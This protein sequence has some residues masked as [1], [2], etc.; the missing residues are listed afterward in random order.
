M[1]PHLL[2]LLLLILPMVGIPSIFGTDKA[3]RYEEDHTTWVYPPWEHTWGIVRATQTHLT[4]YSMGASQFINP[5]GLAVVR[6]DASNDPE[7]R[8]DD[9][10]VTVYGVNSGE[11][12]II[13]NKSMTS[14]GFYNGENIPDKPLDQPWDIAALV[15]GLVYITDAGNQRIIKLRNVN[16]ELEYVATFGMADSVG[17]VLPRGVDATD[18]GRVVV[19]DA[20]SNRVLLFDSTGVLTG[21]LTGF[22]RPVGLAAVDSETIFLRPPRDYIVVSDSGGRRIRKLTY[23][24]TLLHE[25]DVAEATGLEN[26]YVGHLAIDLFHNIIATD[27]VNNCILKFDNELDILAVWGQKGKGRS[28]FVGPTGIAAW[29]RFGQTFVAEQGGAHYLWVGTD[30]THPP[31]LSIEKGPIIRLK[32][33]LTERSRITLRLLDRKGELVQDLRATRSAGEQSLNW[34]LNRKQ[35]PLHLDSDDP[36]RVSRLQPPEPGRYILEI[37]LR[38]SYSSSKAFEKVVETEVELTPDLYTN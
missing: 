26:P 15:N 36:I 13:Y 27:S 23:A 35:T 31:R 20:G 28:R 5:Q 38:A 9:D 25:V 22:D 7:S 1:I 4:F 21:E 24:G 8:G 6:L 37:H 19:A 33:G 34:L 18:G 3:A 11:N 14:L 32:L 10:E 12:T 29:R 16:S 2:T 30:F 17:L